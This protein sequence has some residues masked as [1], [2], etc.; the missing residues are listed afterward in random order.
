MHNFISYYFKNLILAYETLNIMGEGLQ[1]GVTWLGCGR[2]N[3]P[4]IKL[5]STII[6]C[7]LSSHQVSLNIQTGLLACYHTDPGHYNIPA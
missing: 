7:S 5:I 1:L 6:K 2:A 4:C 3:F